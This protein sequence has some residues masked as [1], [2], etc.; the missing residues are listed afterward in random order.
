M[1]ASKDDSIPGKSLRGSDGEGLFGG[2]AGDVSLLPST[3][4][5]HI[6]D[7]CCYAQ[8]SSYVTQHNTIMML[9]F[10]SAFVTGWGGRRGR[11]G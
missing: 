5:A 11:N 4:V 3:T 2:A 10:F 8:L 7:I 6:W 9:C 1:L